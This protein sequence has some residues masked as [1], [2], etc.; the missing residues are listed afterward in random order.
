MEKRRGPG[1]ELWDPSAFQVREMRKGDTI[2]GLHFL[3]GNA[4]TV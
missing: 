2:K 3:F 4:Y 1:T